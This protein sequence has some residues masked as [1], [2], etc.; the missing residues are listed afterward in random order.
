MLVSDIWSAAKGSQGYGSCKEGELYEAIT[1]AVHLLSDKGSWD[2]M[3]G[4]MTICAFDGYI[5]M[6]REVE[7]V[8]AANINGVPAFPRDKW[9]VHHLNGV[10]EYSMIDSTNRFYDEVGTVPT[11]RG[12]TEPSLLIGV[13]E[14]DSDEGKEMIVQ[15]YDATDRELF[16]TND[17]GDYVKGIRVPIT[18]SSIPSFKDPST[19]RKITRIIKPQ[20]TGCVSLFAHPQCYDDSSET[21]QI[22]YYYPDETDPRYRKYRFPKASCLSIKYRR[23]NLVFSSQSDFIPF[24]NRLALMLALKAVRT[25]H[26]NNLEGGMQWEEK[27]TALLRQSEEARRQNS[28]IG[29]QVLDYS[30]DN[31]E[32][33]RGSRGTRIRCTSS[34]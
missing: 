8:E 17:N 7:K 10:G 19:V 21:V 31:N 1:E 11:F 33:L 4:H 27:A 32:R 20:T 30:S 14:S 26:T 23:K 29:P 16:H 13:P 22:G 15:G 12:L 6:P 34:C 24:D 5:T 25:Y 9:Y 3:I 28:A 2:W 18:S